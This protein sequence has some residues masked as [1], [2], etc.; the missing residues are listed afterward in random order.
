MRTVRFGIIG[1][2]FITD[3]F[4]EAAKLCENVEIRAIYSRDI[5]KA[6]RLAA[7]KGIPLFFDNLKALSACRQ[8]DAVY[9]ASPNS[10]HFEQTMM[11]LKAKKHVICEKPLAS[12]YA[13]GSV[14]FRC[15]KDNGVFLMEAMRPVFHPV[16]QVI[17]E[18]LKEIGPIRQVTLSYCQYSSRYNKFKRGIIENAFDPS[19]SNGSIMDIGC[20]PIH[21]MVMLFGLPGEIMS[22]GIRLPN[23]IDGNGNIIAHYGEFLANISYSKITDSYLENEIQGENGSVRFYDIASPKNICCRIGDNVQNMEVPGA[24]PDMQ[25]EIREFVNI[26]Q[27]TEYP[28]TYQ[29]YSLDTLHLIDEAREQMK[30][31]FPADTIVRG[32][33]FTN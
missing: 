9:I 1:S 3:R 18:K 2:N 21:V 13:E 32:G 16:Y 22:M 30:I 7:E 29:K 11:M 28:D 4:W 31:V 15:A 27:R 14:M 26:I 8:I 23:S 12:N 24:E 33:F 6:R 10:C 19:L 25:Y 5:N 17:R 20:Y